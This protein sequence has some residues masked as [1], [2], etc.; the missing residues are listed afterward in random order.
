MTELK[1]EAILLDLDG[2][3]IDIDLDKFISAYVAALAGRFADYIDKM[4]FADHLFAATT[5][6]VKNND[7]GLKNRDA[8]YK[9][10]CG[11]I[12][13]ELEEIEPIITHFYRNDFPRLRR[14]GRPLT[15]AKTVVKTIRNRK[16]SL[17]LATNA[18]FPPEAVYQRVLWADLSIDLFD[19]VTTMDNMHFCKPNQNYYLEI[20]EKI[21]IHPEKC[22]MAGNDTIEDLVASE[23]GMD[24]FLVDDYIL[25]RSDGEP[26]SD[27][28]GSLD[29]LARFLKHI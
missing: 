5:A 14:F 21:G 20:A 4:A 1:Y 13:I 19:L 27:Y 6:M 23:A 17:V 3:L 28:R 12:G 24:T 15:A 8:F 29:D 18:I 25:N 16:L 26:V 10:F 11:R 9:E 2:T 22:L 7:P